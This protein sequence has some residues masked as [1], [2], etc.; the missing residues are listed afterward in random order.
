MLRVD[1]LLPD[2]DCARILIPPAD[3]E[4]LG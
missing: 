2:L 1:A 4:A 3:I